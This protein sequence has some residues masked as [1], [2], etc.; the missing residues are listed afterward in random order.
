MTDLASPPPRSGVPGVSLALLGLVRIALLC[1]LALIAACSTDYADDTGCGPDVHSD[2]LINP[3]SLTCEVHP[4]AV[5]CSWSPTDLSW[6]ACDSPCRALDEATCAIEPGCRS[7]YDHD[8]FFGV[9][10]C[11]RVPFLGCYPLDR[12][13]DLATGCSGL[14]AWSCSRHPQC[15]GTYRTTATGFAYARCAPKPVASP[16]R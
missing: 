16:L 5:P 14:D 13:L 2:H 11:E 12:N 15:V 7:A 1:A 6:G 3:A 8:C 4:P 10:A 9:G